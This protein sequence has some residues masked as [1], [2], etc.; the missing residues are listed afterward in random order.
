MTLV[1]ASSL[2]QLYLPEHH[3]SETH[4]LLVKAAP[5]RVLDAAAGYDPAQDSLIRAFITLRE[6]P[7]RLLGAIG[8]S[9]GL[10]QRRRFGLSDFTPLGR[11]GDSELAFGLAG[12]FWRA[13]YGLAKLPSAEG[14]A[15]FAA[16]RSA[17]LVLNFTTSS[18]RGAVLLTTQTRIFCSDEVA[19]RRFLPYWLL[20]RPVSG[21]IRRR[22]LATIRRNAE[23]SDA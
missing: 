11:V 17:K 12:Q 13:D 1:P 19:R 16:P 6:A 23:H 2:S 22:I 3:F 14:F 8:L 9:S 18:E 5:G 10:R 4:S 21:L 20:I 15:A 7:G